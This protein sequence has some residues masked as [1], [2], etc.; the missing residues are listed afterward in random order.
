MGKTRRAE[1]NLKLK[2]L[3]CCKA[4]PRTS[5]TGSRKLGHD[6]DDIPTRKNGMSTK[7]RVGSAVRVAAVAI[8]TALVSLTRELI[9][10]RR[11]LFT[12]R[13]E[14]CSDGLYTLLDESILRRSVFE[15]FS[16]EW[17]LA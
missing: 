15:F 11:R 4:V 7:R 12:W 3:R 17:R 8:T 14:R 13:G 2:A 16:V 9:K 10:A 5:Y 1:L 6:D